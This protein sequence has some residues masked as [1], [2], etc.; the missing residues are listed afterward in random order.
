MPSPAALASSLQQM[1]ALSALLAD[2]AA[3]RGNDPALAGAEIEALIRLVP[4][5]RA[6]FTGSHDG[7]PAIFRFHLH[8]PERSARRDWAELTRAAAH[9]GQGALRVCTPYHL[10]LPL[11]LV[12]TERAPGLPLMQKIW[13]TPRA[14]RPALLPAAALWLKAYTAPTA[15]LAPIRPEGWLRRAERG[16]ARLQLSAL[17]PLK[18]AILAELHRLAALHGAGQWRTAICHGDFHPNNLL[19]EGARLTGIDT[20][21]SA[22][23]PVCKDVARFLAHMGR[24]RL[25]LSGATRYGVDRAGLAIFAD[26]LELAPCERRIWLPFMIGVEA[27]VR[28]ETA[29]LPPGRIRG[30]EAFCTELLE[31]LRALGG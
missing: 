18:S 26:T 12:V 31:D 3:A 14:E 21:G 16:L 10:A 4:G 30:S 13:R 23:L 22:R 29:A 24:R 1:D 19:A 8:A 6:I 7:R 20:G 2:F 5:K 11:G 28:V 15:D 9:M 25:H 17:H 27:L